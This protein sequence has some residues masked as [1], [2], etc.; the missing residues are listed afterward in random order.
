MIKIFR[1]IRQNLLA[2]NKF[3]RYIIY[4]LGEVILVVVGIL[5]ALG[6]NNWNSKRIENNKSELFLKNLKSQIEG[7]ISLVT[8]NIEDLTYY[9]DS[10]KK[11]ITVIGSE[12]EKKINEV[13]LD[14]LIMNNSFDFHLNLN[15]NTIIQGRENGTLT[16]LKSDSLRQT[17][18]SF[19]SLHKDLI[20]REK[21][22]NENLNNK[23]LPYLNKNYNIRNLAVL[24]SPED[25]IGSSKI[26]KNDN[27]KVLTNQEFENLITTRIFN[28]MEILF[29]YIELK[30]ILEEI[31]KL[32]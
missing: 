28:S 21:I 32:I 29:L 11:L 12:E 30:I 25:N 2:E 31:L 3:S 17:I 15:I 6:V 1:K 22:T 8:T 24:M 5:I 13:K 4:A 23:F 26:Y 7:N 18:Y 10:S 27:Y 9:Y 20:E 19:I 14:T 16:L